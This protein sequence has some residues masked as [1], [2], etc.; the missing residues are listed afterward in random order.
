MNQSINQSIS[1]QLLLAQD[2]VTLAKLTLRP[3]A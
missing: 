2:F 1:M 3:Q